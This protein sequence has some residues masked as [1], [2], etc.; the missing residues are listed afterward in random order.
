MADEAICDLPIEKFRPGVDSLDDFF[1]RLKLSID[2]VHNLNGEINKDLLK[3]WLPLKLDAATFTILKNCDRQAGWEDLKAQ[4][5]SLL[6]TQ[7]DR[8]R[9]RSGQNRVKWD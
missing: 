8:Y 5:K 1:Q 2:L 6:V 3:K 9:W 7:Q 4:L